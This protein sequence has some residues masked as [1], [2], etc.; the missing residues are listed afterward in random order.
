[1]FELP[2]AQEIFS[3]IKKHAEK[4]Q[5]SIDS[6]TGLCRYRG[7][8]GAKCF[9]GLLIPDECYREEFEGELWPDLRKKYDLPADHSNLIETLQ[10]V[11]DVRDTEDWDD[12]LAL[13][14]K[15]F[16]LKNE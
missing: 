11:H 1:M 10:F 5:K 3:R 13:A 12:R 8:N 9:A 6:G 14:A 7:A 15:E 2:D 16:G 4:K